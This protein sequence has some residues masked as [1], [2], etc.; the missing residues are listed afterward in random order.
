MNDLKERTIRG[1]SARI[2]SQGASF[3]LRVGSVM[4]LAR[5]LAPKDFGL[6]GMVTA[7][8]GVLILFR[9]FGPSSAAVQR[10]A[11]SDEQ[12]ST[13]FCPLDLLRYPQL[14]P[15]LPFTTSPSGLASA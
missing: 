8:T 12:T 5:L 10:D 15:P 13:L 6:V 2:C 1:G 4:I 9:D 7:F 14:L 11:V 3:L